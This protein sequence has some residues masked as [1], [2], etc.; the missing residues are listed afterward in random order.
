[1]VEEY[2][3]DKYDVIG[4]SYDDSCDDYVA[5]R[6][7]RFKNSRHVTYFGGESLLLPLKVFEG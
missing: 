7:Q 5:E 4:S 1:M 6:R 3:K 2:E